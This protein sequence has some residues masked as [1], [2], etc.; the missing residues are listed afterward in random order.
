MK[1]I[2]LISVLFILLSCAPKIVPVISKNVKI[3]ENFALINKKQYDIAI[4]Y[5]NWND[6]PTNL[7]NYF[8]VFYIIFRNKTENTISIDKN[9]IVLLDD[10]NEQYNLFSDDEVIKIM[11]GDENFYDFTVLDYI[12]QNDVETE[13]REQI[14]EERDNRLEGIRNIKLKSFQFSRI[15]PNAQ[16]SGIIFFE[17]INIKK[18]SIF[19][20]YFKNEIIKFAITE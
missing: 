18:N 13:Y 16:E 6:A 11:Y 15:R 8:S 5:Q 7:E 20:I 10:E 12:L 4:E 19:K 9:S 17:K 3:K 1:K 2:W 14:Q